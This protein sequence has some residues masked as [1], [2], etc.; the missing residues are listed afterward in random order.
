MKASEK[1]IAIMK[2]H[3]CKIVHCPVSNMI[4]ASGFAPI[5]AFHEAGLDVGIATDGAASND[6]LNYLE[7]LKST[8]TIHKGFAQDATVLSAEAV[9]K[10]GNN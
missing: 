5:E 1:D 4:L 7:V 8:A 2:K 9:V 6:S 3:N 10:N